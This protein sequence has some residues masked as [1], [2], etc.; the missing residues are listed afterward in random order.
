VRALNPEDTNHY[1]VIVQ[2]TSG[3]EQDTAQFVRNNGYPVPQPFVTNLS[4][5]ETN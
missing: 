5:V 4:A 2:L 3:H 1:Y